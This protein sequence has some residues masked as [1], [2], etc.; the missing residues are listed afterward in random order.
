MVLFGA[1]LRGG[2]CSYWPLLLSCSIP[3]PIRAGRGSHW[4][5]AKLCRVPWKYAGHN[6]PLSVSSFPT[7]PLSTYRAYLLACAHIT[8]II[9]RAILSHAPHDVRGQC[10][11]CHN[12]AHHSPQRSL[13]PVRGDSHHWIFGTSGPRRSISAHPTESLGVQCVFDQWQVSG[14]HSIRGCGRGQHLDSDVASGARI[15]Y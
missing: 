7:S 13:Q 8:P 2:L 5:P 9:L 3:H 15:V 11:Q 1:L 12:K 6:L 10:S 4:M 14:P